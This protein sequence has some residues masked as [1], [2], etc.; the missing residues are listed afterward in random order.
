V[1]DSLKVL[2]LT[3]QTGLW[4]AQVLRSIEADRDADV[5]DDV[6]PAQAVA[7]IRRHRPDVIGLDMTDLGAEG[8]AAALVRDIL[9][10]GPTPI[11]LFVP[12]GQR[13]ELSM[14]AVV[15]GAV[16]VMNVPAQ[17]NIAAGA[18]LRRRL[19]ALGRLSPPRNRARRMGPAGQ[20]GG[21][22]GP[23][24]H[25]GVERVVGLAASTGG[26]SALAAVLAGLGGLPLPVVVVQHLQSG[27]VDGFLSWMQRESAL[28]VELA[29]DGAPL[30]AG[31]VL[32]GPPGLHVLVAGGHRLA[33]RDEPVTLHR[34]SADV[35]F[36]SMAE[37]C[38]AGGIGVVLTGMGDDGAAGLLALR[39]KGG[40]TMAQ[41]A[42][43]SA[44]YGMPRA[45]CD[46]GAA[47]DVLPLAEI[48]AAVLRA[49][50]AEVA[51]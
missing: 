23:L 18:E 33:L 21:G 28:P 3:S 8:L 38:G 22:P 12:A 26:P 13:R 49:A 17:W 41:D 40:T 44:V 46:N 9:S 10:V 50:G 43:T 2:V 34:P 37:R 16:E 35:L 7:S 42:A 20:N 1:K 14:A 6:G 39:Q 24:R 47:A 11:L 36:H 4:R 19:H 25:R 27:F 51:R 30:R 31:V 15:A 32:V 45:A 5:V 29:V 48:P